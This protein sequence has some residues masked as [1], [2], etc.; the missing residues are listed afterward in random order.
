MANQLSIR[1]QPCPVEKPSRVIEENSAK[2]DV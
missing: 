2:T 1:E